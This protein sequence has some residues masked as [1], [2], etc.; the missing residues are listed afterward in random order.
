MKLRSL[1]LSLLC[2]CGCSR[3][4]VEFSIVNP[5]H[6]HASM[7]LREPLEG[8][9]RKVNVYA[10]QGPELESFLAD[11][12]RFNIRAD[13]PASWKPEVH[14]DGTLPACK[15][16]GAV[17]LAGK[18]SRKAANILDAVRKGYSVLS[19]KPM[20][21]SPA[22]YSLLEEA[23]RIAAG[24]GLVVMD[25][26]TERFDEINIRTRELLKGKRLA[27]GS[28][29]APCI[30]MESSHHFFK[31]VDGVPLKRPAWYYDVK[32]QGEGI[33]DVTTHLVDLIMWQC[34]PEIPVLPEDV[35]LLDASHWPTAVSPEQYFRSTGETAFPPFLA[36]S[37]DGDGI[38]Q[39]NCNGTLTFRIK[40]IY[41]RLT[42]RWDFEDGP[43]TFGAVYHCDGGDVC[44][45][46][47]ESTGYAK[48]LFDSGAD[49]T[50][51]RKLSHED[52]FSLV[53]TPRCLPGKTPIPLQNTGC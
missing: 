12:Q 1:L 28:P 7:V 3:P 21:I 8:V 38:L 13:N 20:A 4:Q 50:P 51:E 53:A 32:E 26:M 6:F 49:V 11:V 9:S 15:G 24:K 30:E 42:V 35:E 17:V 10:P 33:A 36:D 34:F 40:D 47:D 31:T 18:N 29:E 14:I 52:H 45:I 25:L 46:Q 44:L 37:V 39:V 2:L 16:K 41:A 48:R 19:D 43:D 23:Y 22:D 5:G 27:G